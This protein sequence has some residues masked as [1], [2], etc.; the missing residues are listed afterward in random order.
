M[1]R[2][3]YL[4]RHAETL[5]KKPGETDLQREL[6]PKGLS[7]ALALQKYMLERKIILDTIVHSPASR[8]TQT[9]LLIN[10]PFSALLVKNLV[11]Y[12]GSP[13]E[14]VELIR[15]FSSKSISAA[16]VGHNPTI[17]WLANDL[18]NEPLPN[19]VPS[20]MVCLKFNLASWNEL[21]PKCG[22]LALIKVPDIS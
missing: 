16:I 2:A 15:Q 19:F 5:E 3:L 4:I 14:L 21:K 1:E 6:T 20:T 8:T 9:A 10:K 12:T 13:V 7:D 17:S 22:K 18:C 11:I